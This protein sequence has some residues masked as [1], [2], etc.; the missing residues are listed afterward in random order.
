MFKMSTIEECPLSGAH[1]MHVFTSLPT[2]DESFGKPFVKLCM[3]SA[4]VRSKHANIKLSALRKNARSRR[5]THPFMEYSAPLSGEPPSQAFPVV[6]FLS[7]RS[8]S[9]SR[10]E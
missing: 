4:I 9:K 2:G 8:K 5:C 3:L 10:R 7:L 1:C 6:L